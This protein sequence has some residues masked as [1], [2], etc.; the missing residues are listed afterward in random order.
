LVAFADGLKAVPFERADLKRADLKRADLKRADLKRA[1]LKRADLE[2]AD[3]IGV[4]I[5]RLP[6]R[7]ASFLAGR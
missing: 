1:D 4:S 2:R 6:T 7:P 5:D 3:L